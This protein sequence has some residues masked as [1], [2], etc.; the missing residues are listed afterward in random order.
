MHPVRD[1]VASAGT[2]H[3]RRPLRA[4]TV[5]VRS[6]TRPSSL[7]HE[8]SAPRTQVHRSPQHTQALGL[9]QPKRLA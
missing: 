3:L 9:T 8:L 7:Y 4:S 6:G 1:G 5:R 2:E